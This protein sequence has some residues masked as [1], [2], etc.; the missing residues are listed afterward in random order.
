L[1]FK[2]IEKLYA[3]PRAMPSGDVFYKVGGTFSP[4]PRRSPE[5]NSDMYK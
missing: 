5:R 3:N 1:Y 2:N 4:Y